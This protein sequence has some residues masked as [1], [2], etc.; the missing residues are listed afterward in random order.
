MPPVPSFR[1]RGGR[2]H[3]APRA[4]Q[5]RSTKPRSG[6]VHLRLLDRLIRLIRATGDVLGL[7]HRLHS[8]QIVVLSVVFLVLVLL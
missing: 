2:N 5:L 7:P 3:R 6:P 1:P 8:P 4:F